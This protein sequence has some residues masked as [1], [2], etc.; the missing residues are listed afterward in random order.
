MAKRASF[1]VIFSLICSFS[2]TSYAADAQYY[3]R[4]REKCENDPVMSEGKRCCLQSVKDMEKGGFEEAV[5]GKCLNGQ[6]VN[7]LLCPSAYTWC[8]PALPVQDK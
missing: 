4:L 5:N 8:E 7:S 2:A 1:I 6:Q 3:A